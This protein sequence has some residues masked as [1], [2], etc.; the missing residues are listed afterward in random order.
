MDDSVAGSVGVLDRFSNH[1]N[2]DLA[3]IDLMSRE[4]F[5]A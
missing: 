1:R 5:D 4:P 2:A 3:A